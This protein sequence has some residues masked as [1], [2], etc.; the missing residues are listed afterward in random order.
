MN[1]ENRLIVKALNMDLE[2]IKAEIRFA[3][4]ETKNIIDEKL[5]MK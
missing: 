2:K 5:F 4:D 3:K 1:D